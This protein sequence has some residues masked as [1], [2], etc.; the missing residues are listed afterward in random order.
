M[1]IDHIGGILFTEVEVLRMIGRLAFP[2]FAFQLAQGYIH[3][4]NFKKYM[5][6][7]WIFALISQVP[8]MLAFDTYKLNIMFTFIISL[9]LIDK[10]AKKEYSWIFPIMVVPFI[11]DI[12]YGLYGILLPLGF[13]LARNKKI[14]A[15]FLTCL[16]VVVYAL[17]MHQVITLYAILGI[18]IALYFPKQE[19]KLK[20]NR[21]FFYWFYPIHIAILFIIKMIL[22]SLLV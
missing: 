22:L 2:I 19:I 18:A 15:F 3:T 16:M 9:F 14:V 10:I 5:F 21:Y 13:Y 20:M 1:A 7:I 8:Y 6:R 4:S 17:C 11:V 12:D